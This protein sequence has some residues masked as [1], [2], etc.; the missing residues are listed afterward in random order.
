MS[1]VNEIRSAFLDYFRKHGHEVVPSSPLFCSEPTSSSLDYSS[2]SET[3]RYSWA[4][5]AH[6]SAEYPRRIKK[7]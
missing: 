5:L 3:L 7:P 6:T 4:T 2:A 1:G